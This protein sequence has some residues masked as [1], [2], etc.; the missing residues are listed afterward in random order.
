ML[1]PG[2]HFSTF[3]IPVSSAR[4]GSSS[5]IWFR[6]SASVP[7]TLVWASLPP[8]RP[9]FSA[10][11]G[12]SSIRLETLADSRISRSPNEVIDS[13]FLAN[14]GDRTSMDA[15]SIANDAAR[16][17]SSAWR[18]SATGTA[19]AAC[20]GA[21]TCTGAGGV[22]TR[23]LLVAAP[24]AG[25]VGVALDP[26]SRSVICELLE[27]DD[28]GPRRSWPCGAPPIVG[29][30]STGDP[31]A[32]MSARF[33]GRSPMARCS[34]RSAPS[35]PTGRSDDEG[36]TMAQDQPEVTPWQSFSSPRCS[37]TSS[38]PRWSTSRCRP[39][40]RTSGCRSNS[41]QR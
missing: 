18:A 4:L 11:A 9:P 36:V 2:I 29:P 32:P 17:C 41:P 26:R 13:T 35:T 40:P 33:L 37:S 28:T 15:S 31:A 19:P 21:T 3:L 16:L 27:V 23:A 34:A 14:S 38:M 30:A 1:P 20:S 39:S 6:S 5:V 7:A 12:R 25:P 22:S 8:L 24:R 10:A